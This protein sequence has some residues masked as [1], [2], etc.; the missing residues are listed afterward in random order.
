MGG[1]ILP[2]MTQG[3]QVAPGGAELVARQVSR[4]AQQPGAKRP[5]QVKTRQGVEGV[6]ES[7]LNDILSLIGIS[8]E[9]MDQAEGRLLVG[10]QQVF[11]GNLIALAGVAD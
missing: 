5:G 6:Y 2:E 9:Q 3:S 10:A 11:P 4:D 8:Q 1:L 7:L